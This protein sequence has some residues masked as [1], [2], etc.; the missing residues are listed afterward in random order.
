MSELIKYAILTVVC[1][2]LYKQCANTYVM[3]IKKRPARPATGW[4]FAI[5]FTFAAMVYCVIMT[6]AVV[7]GVA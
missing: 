1:W 7:A 3:K 6:L 4:A 5:I 2:V